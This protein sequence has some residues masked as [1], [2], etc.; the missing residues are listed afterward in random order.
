MKIIL[1]IYDEYYFILTVKRG[2]CLAIFYIIRSLIEI[3]TDSFFNAKTISERIAH[4]IDS[5]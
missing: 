3:L 1:H 5:D 4:S 2:C